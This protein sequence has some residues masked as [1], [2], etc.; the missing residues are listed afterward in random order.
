MGIHRPTQLLVNAQIEKGETMKS[1]LSVITLLLVSLLLLGC[2]SNTSRTELSYKN[3]FIQSIQQNGY[4]AFRSQS[5]SAI[6]VDQ[7]TVYVFN[8]DNKGLHIVFGAV[9][10]GFEFEYVFIDDQNLTIQYLKDDQ[11]F[12]PRGFSLAADGELQLVDNRFKSGLLET[13]SA[14]LTSSRIERELLLWPY[15]QVDS[16]DK[17]I[18]YIEKFFL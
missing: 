7:D 14:G 12:R 11:R 6:G 8:L 3:N 18:Q 17:Y 5:G 2:G 16:S 15:Q 9:V 13:E 4:I 1:I 10:A